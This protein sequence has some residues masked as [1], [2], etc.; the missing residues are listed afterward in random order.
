MNVAARPKLESFEML[1]PKRESRVRE[2]DNSVRPNPLVIRL[3]QIPRGESLPI[4]I[5]EDELEYRITVPVEGIDPRKIYVFAAPRWLLIEIR[6]KSSVC[7]E[8]ARALVTESIDRR[9]SRKFALPV[10]IEKGAT[11]VRV[12]NG[13]LYITALKSQCEQETFW[14]QLIHFDMRASLDFT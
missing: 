14:S 13:S 10:E 8:L 6:F 5:A 9:I 7:H 12:S 3:P 2:I 11:T 1:A 4:E